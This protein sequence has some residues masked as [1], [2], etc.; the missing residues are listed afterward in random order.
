MPEKTNFVR[1]GDFAPALLPKSA[2]KGNFTLSAVRKLWYT[3]R[4]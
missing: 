3:V 2:G 1:R 4:Q